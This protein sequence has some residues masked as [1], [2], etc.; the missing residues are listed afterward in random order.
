M[1]CWARFFGT[2]NYGPQ[3]PVRL[4]RDG[5]REPLDVYQRLINANFILNVTRSPISRKTIRIWPSMSQVGMLSSSSRGSCVS[6]TR[7]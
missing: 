2:I 1:K 5:R 4:Y 3:E 6:L 7:R